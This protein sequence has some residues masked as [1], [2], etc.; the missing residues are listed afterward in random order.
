MIATTTDIRVKNR[1]RV[2]RKGAGLSVEEM[3][4]RAGIARSTAFYA[5]RPFT[6]PT[7]PIAVRIARALAVDVTELMPE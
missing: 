2:L 3:A 6:T 4:N 5:D 7:L 1:V